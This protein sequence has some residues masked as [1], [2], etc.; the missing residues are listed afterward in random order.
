VTQNGAGAVSIT[1]PRTIS[2]SG[3]AVNFLKAV[4]LAGGAS[5]LVGIDTTVTVAAGAT[6]TFQNTLDAT[7]A[8]PNAEGLTLNA[9]LGNIAFND[10]IGTSIASPTRPSSLTISS[11]NLVTFSDNVYINGNIE[12]RSNDLDISSAALSDFDVEPGRTIRFYSRT[13]AESMGIGG[14][15]G[16][17]TI[18]DAELIKIK[19]ASTIIFGLAGTQSG[20]ITVQTVLSPVP[21]AAI[22][23]NSNNGAGAVFFDDNFGS[24]PA[25]AFATG[26]SGSITVRAGTGGITSIQSVYNTYSELSTTGMISLDSAGVIALADSIGGND[27]VG[28]PVVPA[29][30]T[31]SSASTTT[32]HGLMFRT[33]GNQSWTATGGLSLVD[34]AKTFQVDGG[35]NTLTFASATTA[36]VG[37]TLR[38]DNIDLNDAINLG[39][40][41]LELYSKNP[42]TRPILLG[43]VDTGAALTLTDAELARIGPVSIGALIIG[44][45]GQQASP[46]TF[47]TANLS[48]ANG[49]SGL[50]LTVNA[51]AANGYVRFESDTLNDSLSLGT[52]NLTVNTHSR[53]EAAQIPSGKSDITTTGIITLNTHATAGDRIGQ[54]PV[55]VSP[56]AGYYP[57]VIATGHTEV[58]VS[59]SNV[60]GVFLMGNG[61]NVKL[62]SVAIGGP[63]YTDLYNN[64]GTIYL[65]KNINSGG[66]PVTFVQPVR[67]RPDAGPGSTITIT[68]GN[69]D[70]TFQKSLDEDDAGGV[71]PGTNNLALDAGS[72]NIAF[73]QAIGSSKRIGVL[74]ISSVTSASFSGVVTAASFS[75]TAGFGTTTF[76]GAV[77]M[78]TAAGLVVNAANIVVNSAVTTTNGGIVTMNPGT[79]LTI[80]AAGD[81][82]LDGA[83]TQGGA[84]TVYTAGDITTTADSVVWGSVVV[85]T[86]D[87]ALT[88]AGGLIDFK[89]T[90][91][92]GHN[93]TLTAGGGDI[94][95]EGIVGTTRLGAISIASARDVTTSYAVSA[96]SLLQAAGT[97]TTTFSSTQDYSGAMS[98]VGTNLVMNGATAV[99]TN[100]SFTGTNLTVNSV[101][102]VGGTTTV[103][104]SGLFTM[105]SGGTT[106]A[107]ASTGAF[108]QNGTGTNSLGSNITTSNAGISFAK[109]IVLTSSI[110]MS[111][112]S[113]AGD[114]TLSSTVEPTTVNSE[115]LTLLAGTGAI[116][117]A[118]SVGGTKRLGA[119]TI[120]NVT[121]A[122]FAGA[123]NAVTFTQA[124][125]MGTTTFSST[126]DYSG[127]MSFVGTNLVMNGAATVGANFSF[128]GANLTVNSGWTVGGTTAVTNS[129]T[130][131]TKSGNAAALTSTGAF[132]QSGGGTSSLG[133]GITT[134]NANI[135]FA[136][137]IV[138][139]S[140]IT[141]STGSGAGDITLSSTVNPTT[142][143]TEGLTLVAGTGNISVAGPVGTSASLRLGALAVTSATNANFVNA[144]YGTSFTQLAG[145]G[146]TTFSSTQDYSGA[147]SF[148]GTNLVIGGTASVGSNFSFTGENLTVHNAWTVGGTTTVTNSGLF[149]TASGGTTAALVSS[150]AFMQNG[151]GTNSLGSNIT[152][153][154]SSIGFATAIELSSSIQMSTGSGAGDITLS[155][156]VNPVATGS[157]G[158]TLAAGTG[159]IAVTGPVGTSAAPLRIG[160]FVIS[161]ATNATF[162]GAIY[163]TSFTQLAGT[164]TTTFI[165]AQDY[166]GAFSFSG[167]NLDVKAAVLALGGFASSGTGSFISEAGASITSNGGATSVLANGT[168]VIGGLINTTTGSI[169][170]NSTTS[171]LSLNA[172]IST[173]SGAVN[174]DSASGT[175]LAAS[176]GI[177]A[178]DASIV[179]FGAATTGVGQ[180]TLAANIASA[181]GTATFNRAVTHMAGTI[182]AGALGSGSALAFKSDYTASGTAAIAGSTV[183]DPD[184]EFDGNTT[185][186]TFTH[187][188]DRLA[189][190]GS[191]LQEF[192]S[193][194]QVVGNVIIDKSGG[195]VVVKQSGTGTGI[196]QTG[197]SYTTLIAS[198][199]LD[200]ATNGDKVGWVA[201][202]A[203]GTAV[204]VGM[205]R[206]IA[207]TLQFN[208]GSGSVAREL[209]LVNLST[210]SGYAVKNDASNK[211]TA[212][213][214][215][216]IATASFGTPTN[217][218]IVMTG[219]GKTITA[220][221]TLGSLYV[222]KSETG[223]AA[224]IT[225]SVSLGSA[226]VFA[227]GLVIGDEGALDVSSASY[228]ITITGNLW[229]NCAEANSTTAN[230]VGSSRFLSRNGEVVFS[231]G[232][233]ADPVNIYGANAWYKLTCVSTSISAGAELRFETGKTQ[234]IVKLFTM[235]GTVSNAPTRSASD[236]YSNYQADSTGATSYLVLSRVGSDQTSDLDWVP[237][238][239]APEASKM[240][241]IDVLPGGTIDLKYVYLKYSD[242]RAHPLAVSGKVVKLFY[243]SSVPDST[244]SKA[245]CFQWIT[246]ILAV[247]SYT[248]DSDGN[249]K[250][251]RIRVTT[252]SSLNYDFSGFT[253]KVSQSDAS[254]VSYEVD[255]SRSGTVKGFAAKKTGVAPY[256]ES[257]FYIYLKEKPY[258]D[259][260]V[261]LSW[262]IERNT[263]LKDAAT[264]G[265]ELEIIA[266]YDKERKTSMVTADTAKPRIAYTLALPGRKDVFYHF[267]EGVYGAA[268]AELSASCFS[269]PAASGDLTAVSRE[270][271]ADSSGTSGIS[272]ALANY[273]SAP[274]LAAIAGCTAYSVLP[275]VNDNA[276]LPH[277]YS[278]DSYWLSLGRQLPA[279]Y[280]DF[281]ANGVGSNWKLDWPN[282]IAATSHRVSDALI[283]VFPKKVEDSAYFVWPF[284]AK[285]EVNIDSLLKDISKID[286]MTTEKV[287]ENWGPG[288]VRVFDGSQWL[289]EQTMTV[290]SMINPALTGATG[291]ELHY[292]VG[293]EAAAIAGFTGASAGSYAAPSGLWLPYHAETSFSGLDN[294]PNSTAYGGSTV[295]IGD[296]DGDV[297]TATASGRTFRDVK[298]DPD[299]SRNARIEPLKYVQFFYTIPGYGSDEAP[300]YGLRLDIANSVEVPAN[301]YRL[302]RPFSIY[303]HNVNLQRG[304]VT[305][306]NNVI[307]P[308]NNETVRLDVVVE[309]AGL[310]TINVFTLDG[311][312]ITTLSN[313]SLGTGEYSFNWDGKNGKGLAVARGV[314]FIRVVGQGMD[315]IRKV[316]VVR[317]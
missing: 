36:A 71:L 263:S 288:L 230:T 39:T 61:A 27:S 233:A 106:A 9:G 269:S 99:G 231:G 26:G 181:K 51:D 83:F 63:I 14:A 287:T 174:L 74:S 243:A 97:G 234:T 167:V 104:N 135:S 57:I 215:V 229:R 228:K 85:L 137:P 276:A 154:N 197:E 218:T 12:I 13:G 82:G 208:T 186:A 116:N 244:H 134:T 35:A 241:Q 127:A 182:T 203:A 179:T 235:T 130:F 292:D 43:D 295:T 101:W 232:S 316:M 296:V 150:G 146:A 54:G 283:S 17:W 108:T 158:L 122:G 281:G 110:Q 10:I 212:S 48:G 298:I 2:T 301:W 192:D 52:R 38:T 64:A 216:T 294:Y 103:T 260:G 270:K 145:T 47:I 42:A 225:A 265:Y 109:A 189:F 91:D 307:D 271:R 284:Y 280:N 53:I 66:Q 129:L 44:E 314:Y 317:R 304:S 33:A 79:K 132:T 133:S 81:M 11:A 151:T 25:T 173:D 239:G 172:P 6:I 142:T 272:E 250:I 183:T 279:P 255:T 163:G 90:L 123:V 240:W 107:L 306:L 217:S 93:L 149:T 266:S 112:G 245:T 291:L 237:S 247:N 259:T 69:G 273:E 198:G 67:L 94:N 227:S 252:E 209:R 18:S 297:T 152:T 238:L 46:V 200:L 1:A 224:S 148:L 268:A 60:G 221:P 76:N 138:L 111:T 100:F 168:I 253:V 302:L 275:A 114:I 4:T 19:R 147:L 5:G 70:I 264:Q 126:Q 214:D 96:A 24:T 293:T 223:T 32:L 254:S 185:F 117:V 23:F 21:S 141:L 55:V 178:T 205:Y 95:F 119:L 84:G 20:A 68:S 180:L 222:G 206:G 41:I 305:V 236:L 175:S 207:G 282:P 143:A 131:T 162:T 78:N 160:A 155:D 184:I 88:S 262:Y 257:E 89:S 50:P 169:D 313:S 157:Q 164:G 211:V 300:L 191:G 121:N 37:V 140:G 201:D 120:T 204:T 171:T 278:T 59:G 98:F 286:A 242:A 156:T 105:T 115:G 144:V 31:S 176:S 248:E 246:N 28:G 65:T 124:A 161:S 196:H 251:D 309:T 49:G 289:R 170:L 226:L 267:S 187:Y 3:D 258:N 102:T 210:E 16:T 113:G 136:N 56:Y 86:G 290:R 29:S 77:S 15:A 30:L 220:S 153:A 285:D 22:E 125:G 274:D 92:G 312:L 190:K 139:T 40:N 193:N 188:D 72:G 194:D 177:S 202:S 219:S 58:N 166:T 118:G 34:N 299:E 73:Q 80:A 277:D 165:T 310:V 128:T 311:D 213:G 195:G 261:T 256:L 199:Y 8:A 75:Q 303:I 159:N 62:G 45:A 87:L 7:T 249:G 308:T 315:E